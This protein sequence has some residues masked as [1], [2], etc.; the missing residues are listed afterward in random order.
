MFIDNPNE[1]PEKQPVSQIFKNP[2]SLLVFSKEDNFQ[3]FTNLYSTA[4][5]KILGQFKGEVFASAIDEIKDSSHRV[6]NAI[7]D[8]QGTSFAEQSDPALQKKIVKSIENALVKAVDLMSDQKSR[9][10]QCTAAAYEMVERISKTAQMC[11]VA[12]LQTERSKVDKQ[13][14]DKLSSS[15]LSNFG[16]NRQ[17]KKNTQHVEGKETKEKPKY[18]QTLFNF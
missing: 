6:Y 8:D 4:S 1:V 17:L 9:V 13:Y 2:N 18:R 15:K 11:V 5:S 14:A 7:K 10:L 12:M 16:T 3:K